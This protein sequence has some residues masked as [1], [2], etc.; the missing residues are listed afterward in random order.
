MRFASRKFGTVPPA[1]GAAPSTATASAAPST[2]TASAAP[3]MA[4]K[5]STFFTFERVVAGGSL[6]SMIFLLGVVATEHKGV[7]DGVTAEQKVLA[8]ERAAVKTILEAEQ[9][10]L[11]TE[12]A[13]VKTE[14]QASRVVT[15]ISAVIAVVAAGAVL[16]R[17]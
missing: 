6:I 11:A 7:K 3:S 14:L 8:T 5:G 16:Y 12:R 15:G 2:A 4:S 9:K 10:V 17:K 13:A 1:N